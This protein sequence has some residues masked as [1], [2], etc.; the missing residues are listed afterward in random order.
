MTSRIEQFTSLLRMDEGLGL[1]DDQR[2][3]A[4]TLLAFSG[5]SLPLPVWTTLGDLEEAP[6]GAL[7]ESSAGI[8][9]QKRAATGAWWEMGYGQTW[10][11]DQIALPVLVRWLP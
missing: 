1:T 8:V 6:R 3:R 2:R 7:I 10:T 11:S 5:C 9:Y 4:A